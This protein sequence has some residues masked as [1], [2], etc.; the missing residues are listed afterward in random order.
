MPFR[1]VAA[2]L[3]TI[4]CAIGTLIAIPL[5]PGVLDKAKRDL[6][7]LWRDWVWRFK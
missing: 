6:Y 3:I 4:F 7:A 5:F 1:A 2:G